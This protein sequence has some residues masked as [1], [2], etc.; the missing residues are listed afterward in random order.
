MVGEIDQL[1]CKVN[2]RPLLDRNRYIATLCQIKNATGVTL[3][4]KNINIVKIKNLIN[5]SFFLKK[6]KEKKKEGSLEW[7]RLEKGVCERPPHAT[8]L[9]FRILIFRSTTLIDL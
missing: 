7:L 6:K 9:I 2:F 8:P 1:L 4:K 3:N 5:S